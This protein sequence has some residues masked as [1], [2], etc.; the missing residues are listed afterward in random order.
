MRLT[1]ALG[2]LGLAALTLAAVGLATDAQAKTVSIETGNFYFCDA[3]KQ[4][5]VC[6]TTG[7]EVGDTVTWTVATG[8]HDVQQCSDATFTNCSGGFDLGPFSA[9]QSKSQTFNT[10]GDI[11]YRCAFHPS[12]MRGE[13]QVVAAATATPTPTTAP[14]Q[15]AAASATATPASVPNTGGPPDNGGSNTLEYILFGAG[16]LLI[17]GALAAFVYARVRR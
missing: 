12:Q 15:T 16:G 4:G 1:F 5:Q 11:Y 7:V 3:G 8:S 9:G 14:S 13:I 6:T 10:A 17:A 2:A